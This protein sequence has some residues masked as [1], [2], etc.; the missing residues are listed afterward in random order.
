MLKKHVSSV[1]KNSVFPNTLIFSRKQKIFCPIHG[2]KTGED[3]I[4][5]IIRH[6][7][8]KCAKQTS[9][10]KWGLKWIIRQG[11]KKK[12]KLSSITIHLITLLD[13][14]TGSVTGELIDR[15]STRLNSSHVAISYA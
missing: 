9:R 12:W 11:K 14:Y 8:I 15:K 6:F 3:F 10:L 13:L 5:K 1:L 2:S 7:S 4:L